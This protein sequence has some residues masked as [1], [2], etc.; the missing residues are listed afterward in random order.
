[1]SIEAG[2]GEKTEKAIS[3]KN[4]KADLSSV[5]DDWKNNTS[6]AE[7]QAERTSIN[8]ALHKF[9]PKLS[10]IDFTTDETGAKYVTTFDGQ[11]NKLQ[12]RTVNDFKV[13]EGQESDLTK[14]MAKKNETPEQ[15][16]QFLTTQVDAKKEA[17][18]KKSVEQ[19]K[20]EEAKVGEVKPYAI[21]PG[22]NLWKIAQRQLAEDNKANGKSDATI[23]VNAVKALVDKILAANQ[24]GDGAIRNANLIYAG[25]TLN[26]PVEKK[27][28]PKTQEEPKVEKQEEIEVKPSSANTE[29]SNKTTTATTST[30][31]TSS[32]NA[33]SDSFTPKS[34]TYYNPTIGA[35]EA[36]KESAVLN[37]F[38]EQ[39]RGLDG[40]ESGKAFVT[41]AEINK[42]VE[43]NKTHLPR[44]DGQPV[45]N[46]EEIELLERAA[47]NIVRIAGSSDDELLFESSGATRKDV[48]IFAEQ[49]KDFEGRFQARFY[50]DKHF[51]RLTAGK[52][53]ISVA[54]IKAYRD[55]LLTR[56]NSE[57]EVRAVDNVLVQL[58]KQGFK[59]GSILFRSNAKA[60]IRD[61][62]AG[63]KY[64]EYGGRS[65][66]IPAVAAK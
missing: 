46:A 47:N 12:R 64:A 22:D 41:A 52:D 65:Y 2:I 5:F 28:A 48:Q 20:T 59:D 21:Q 13:V 1:M 18:G 55:Q 35:D 38:Y 7:N 53:H 3:N 27:E 63:S 32:S 30:T 11:N 19:S 16:V 42:F 24:E 44:T 6:K 34:D 33:A 9:L 56:P 36:A 50:L 39:M 10:I 23:S 60:A 17:D 45:P 43:A 58:G 54:E 37:K 40:D 8:N 61:D 14:D 62:I 29:S 49:E 4:D 57:A 51:D 15:V 66:P 25:K 26:I 31:T